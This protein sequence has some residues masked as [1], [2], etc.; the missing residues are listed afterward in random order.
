MAK[1]LPDKEMTEKDV[2]ILPRERARVNKT[3]KIMA[4]TT[5]TMLH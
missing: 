1:V 3:L 2:Y 4:P 5:K